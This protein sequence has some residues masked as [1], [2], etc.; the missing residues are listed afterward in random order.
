MTKTMSLNPLPLREGA[1]VGRVTDRAPRRQQ[2][3]FL[4]ILPVVVVVA[5]FIVYPLI[6]T[7]IMSVTND[8][9]SFV[10]T[11]NY[12][13]ILHSS[14]TTRATFNTIYYVGVSV[15]MQ[16]VIGTAAGILLNEK[17]R[18][19]SILRAITLL[20]WVVPGI[21][22]A[23]AWAWM[24][25]TDFGIINVLL[26]SLGLISGSVSWLTNP[27]TVMPAQIAVNIWKMFPF[28]AIMVLAG[29]QSIP[30]SLYEAARV[31]GAGFWHEVFHITLPQLRP[32][33]GAITL[34]LLISGVNSITI[35]YAMT[36]GGPADRSMITSLQIYDE[37]FQ[38]FDF[39][40][41]SALSIMFFAVTSLFIALYIHLRTRRPA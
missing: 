29:L 34:L 27:A 21:V 2:G 9:G 12:D 40:E 38:Y 32:V 11:A 37:A 24:L 17:F 7:I 36:Q 20:P 33:L 41:A 1:G 39:G 30:L 28:V 5:I 16:L 31:D 3:P 35:I 6:S 10:G 4:F 18:F 14:R 22:A 26:K 19:Q 15:L 13:S 25:N 23:M 8:A